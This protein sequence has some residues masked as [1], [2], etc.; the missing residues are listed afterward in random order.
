[1][2]ALR[3]DDLAERWV[4]G[5]SLSR[6]MP[7]TRNDRAWQVEV[8]GE[9]RDREYVAVSPTADDVADLAV[10]LQASDR[11]WLTIVGPVGA[12]AHRGL[13]DL[14]ALTRVEA[15]MT[16]RIP[17]TPAPTDVLL[18]IS[19]PVAL[20]RIVVE[21]RLAAHGQ[22]AV[23]GTDAVFDRITTEAEFRRR[24]LGGL[25]MAGLAAWASDQGASAGI[26]VASEMGQRLYSRLGWQVAAPV[27]TYRRAAHPTTR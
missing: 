15:M 11:F 20:A 21:G 24:G 9:T 26:L 10:A 14:E 3:I 16:T 12:D 22:A 18:D 17:S 1:M 2:T 13:D 4:T 27:A 19:G 8:G 5:W 6:G 7:V 23:S 25:L